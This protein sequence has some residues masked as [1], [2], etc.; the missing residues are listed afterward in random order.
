MNGNS[1]NSTVKWVAIIVTLLALIFGSA[2]GAVQIKLMRHD[3][4]IM[5]IREDQA[6]MKSDIKYI[7]ITIDRATGRQSP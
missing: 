5:E 4:I 6:E 7:R 2:Y 3:E 1:N